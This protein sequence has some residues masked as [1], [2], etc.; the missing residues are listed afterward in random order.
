[1]RV[2]ISGN[3]RLGRLLSLLQV[4]EVDVAS[5]ARDCVLF[6]LRDLETRLAP[7]EQ[8]RFAWEMARALRRLKKIAVLPPACGLHASPGVRV[9]ADEGAAR[10]WLA[11]GA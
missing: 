3:P 9:F 4:M 2:T 11:D 1:M 8:A 7:D 6:D 5:W 10:A